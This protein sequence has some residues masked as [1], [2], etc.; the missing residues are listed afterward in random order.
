MWG[1]RWYILPGFGIPLL[2][3]TGGY[4]R[5]LLRERDRSLKYITGFGYACQITRPLQMRR[6]VPIYIIITL[7]L[8]NVLTVLTG[9]CPDHSDQ[10]RLCS[11]AGH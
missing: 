6:F 8:N 3:G 7:I 10:L 9:V 1:Q 4:Y 2:I 5:C 11:P